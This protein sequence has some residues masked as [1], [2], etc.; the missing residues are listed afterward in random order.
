MGAMTLDV[1]MR[2]HYFPHATQHK[3]SVKRDDQLHRL[4][5]GP[6]SATLH[7]RP[8]TAVTC[9]RSRIAC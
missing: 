2:D 5:I 6:S 8:S 1:F 4:R 3:R 7:C 9:R